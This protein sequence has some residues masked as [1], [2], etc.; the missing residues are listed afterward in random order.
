MIEERIPIHIRKEGEIIK[1]RFLN[2]TGR[3]LYFRFE[4]SET[5]PVVFC[6]TLLYPMSVSNCSLLHEEPIDEL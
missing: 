1:S 2:I 5:Y 4:D 6:I 3:H